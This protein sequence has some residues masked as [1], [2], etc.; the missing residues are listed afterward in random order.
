MGR[1]LSMLTLC[2]SSLCVCSYAQENADRAGSVAGPALESSLRSSLTRSSPPSF[3]HPARRGQISQSQEGSPKKD[4]VVG[5]RLPR[6]A[7]VGHSGLAARRSLRFLLQ[8]AQKPSRTRRGEPSHRGSIRPHVRQALECPR[9]PAADNDLVRDLALPSE[10][11]A[12]DHGRRETHA[13]QDE[14]R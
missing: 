12:H 10:E 4:Q 9:V 1:I 5:V 7:H 8:G 2:T 6:L 14:C 11:A 3:A 13:A